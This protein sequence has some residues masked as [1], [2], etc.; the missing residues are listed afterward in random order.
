MEQMTTQ[1]WFF[2]TLFMSGIYYLC[3]FTFICDDRYDKKWKV[4]VDMIPFMGI[5]RIFFSSGW[6]KEVYE[7]YQQ[8]SEE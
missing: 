8:I 7:S 6:H 3:I 5:L 4:W 2:V 1:E